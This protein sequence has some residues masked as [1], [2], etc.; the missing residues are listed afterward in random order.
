MASMKA[1]ARAF[2]DLYRTRRTFSAQPLPGTIATESHMACIPGSQ[3]ADPAKSARSS[4]IF[5]PSTLTSQLDGNAA[6]QTEDDP[7]IHTS[8][9]QKLKLKKRSKSAYLKHERKK[10][11]RKV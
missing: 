9:E 3:S 6:S 2:K 10:S 11:Q 1:T 8:G 7:F 4:R 5:S